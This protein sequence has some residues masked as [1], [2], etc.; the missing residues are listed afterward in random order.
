MNREIKE[1]QV[2]G[3]TKVL[4]E[5]VV[6]ATKLGEQ[7]EQGHGAV[8]TKY[9]HS[10]LYGSG[11]IQDLAFLPKKFAPSP[12][13]GAPLYF[14][15]YLESSFNQNIQLRTGNFEIISKKRF[16]SFSFFFHG[17]DVYLREL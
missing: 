13:F 3:V 16:L 14:D 11:D 17:T 2:D 5:V 9:Q 8:L 4:E 10:S 12:C 6:T 15:I 1:D 7:Q